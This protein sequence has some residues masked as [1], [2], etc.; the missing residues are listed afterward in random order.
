VSGADLVPAAIAFGG[1]VVATPIAIVVARRLDLVDRP[2]PMKPQAMPVP[3]LG[4]SAVLVAMTAGLIGSDVEPLVV[5][6]PAFL[7]GLVDDLRAIPPPIRLA[8]EAIMGLVVVV[9]VPSRGLLASVAVICLTVALINAVNILDGLDGLT[10]GVTLAGALGFAVVLEPPSV[11]MALSGAVAGFL[12]YNRP[13]ARVYLGDSGAYVLGASMAWL[14]ASAWAPGRSNGL[15]AAAILFVA[16]PCAEIGADVLRRVK[17][18]VPMFVHERTHVYDQLVARGWN[19]KVVA[20][21]FVGVQVFFSGCALWASR[22]GTA[23]IAVVGVLALLVLG[24][25]IAGGF[26]SATGSFKRQ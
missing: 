22:L 25:L 1:A 26:L 19:P 14:L 7:L 11:A 18:R 17:N 6:I 20:A 21:T 3:Y 24:V 4:G 5:V 15:L 9:S 23:A 16:V 2:G 13:P 8:V 12:L 10:A